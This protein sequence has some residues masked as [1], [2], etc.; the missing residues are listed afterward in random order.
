MAFNFELDLDIVKMNSHTKYVGQ[1]RFCSKVIIRTHRRVDTQTRRDDCSAWTTKVVSSETSDQSNL[2]QGRIP[3]IHG[4][5]NRTHQVSPV[6]TPNLILYMLQLLVHPSPHAKRR[7]DPFSRSVYGRVSVYF[8]VDCP[9]RHQ[10][11]IFVL[12][13]LDPT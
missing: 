7:I 13:D 8:T 4:R 11:C 9:F 3:A 2:T 10:N 6:C 1:T 12:G 5:F